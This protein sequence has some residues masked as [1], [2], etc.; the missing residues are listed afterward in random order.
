MNKEELK[1]LFKGLSEK[2][3]FE[4]ISEVVNL[5]RL[6]R[7]FAEADI[8]GGKIYS[9]ENKLRWQTALIGN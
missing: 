2:E 7:D 5:E 1:A 3:I 6:K 4:I 8:I 9:R